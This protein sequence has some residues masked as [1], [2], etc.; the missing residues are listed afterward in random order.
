MTTEAV[1]ARIGALIKSDRAPSREEVEELAEA[2][3]S[4]LGGVQ[5]ATTLL[6]IARA[7]AR[8]SVDRMAK[9]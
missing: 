9:R 8:G 6:L 4:Q 3:V 7:F 2:A 1:L 5:A